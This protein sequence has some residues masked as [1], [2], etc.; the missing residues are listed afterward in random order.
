MN[1]GI[2]CAQ[3]WVEVMGS[4]EWNGTNQFQSPC[5]TWEINSRF[6]ALMRDHESW[7]NPPKSFHSSGPRSS[8]IASAGAIGPGYVKQR[9]WRPLEAVAGNREVSIVRG[10]VIYS[11]PKVLSCFVYGW[12]GRW[13]YPG[14]R[15]SGVVDRLEQKANMYKV[16]F[17]QF[18]FLVRVMD[19]GSLP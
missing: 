16:Q 2:W 19:P 10:V 4:M 18:T 7:G 8:N 3:K 5:S 11:N 9:R 1:G 15:R 12:Q 13:P 17:P 6:L 14:K